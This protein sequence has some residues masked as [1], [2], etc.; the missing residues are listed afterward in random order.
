MGTYKP[1]DRTFV[2]RGV[3]LSSARSSAVFPFVS[4]LMYVDNKAADERG[5]SH[6]QKDEACAVIIL[7]SAHIIIIGQNGSSL[8]GYGV[9]APFAFRL[10]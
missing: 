10:V 6:R 8:M 2:C 5:H 7:M 1:P 4:V 9:Y 3:L